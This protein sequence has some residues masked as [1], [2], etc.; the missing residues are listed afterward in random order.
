MSQA[1]SD[2]PPAG[3]SGRERLA[4]V[5]L[6]AALGV[7]ILVRGTTRRADSARTPLDLD[8]LVIHA[9]GLRAEAAT[10]TALA[11]DL[12]FDPADMLLWVNAF[13]QGTDAHRSARSLLDGDLARDLDAPAVELSLPVRLAARGWRTLLIDD[14][15]P[16]ASR[17]QSGFGVSIPIPDAESAPGALAAQW[18]Q[19]ASVAP[20]F[21]FVHLG[22]G[23]EPLHSDTTEAYVLQERY[24]LRLRRIRAVVRDVARAA[25]SGRPQLVV[26]MGA[27][28][29]AL[30]EHPQANELPHDELV[31]VPLLM[32]LRNASGLPTG[33]F[34]A[35][36][37]SADLGP[38]ILDVL[39]LRTRAERATDG[40]ARAGRSLEPHIHGWRTGPVHEELVL[41]GV[42]HV[43]VRSARWKLIA[44]I[45]PP[46][47]PR[48]AGAQ[49]YSLQEDP[50]EL[51][52][53]L[54]G[55]EPG[56]V[57]G[58]LFDV[59]TDRFGDPRASL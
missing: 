29:L 43:A 2:L 44:P 36:V 27:S 54:D 35:L 15:D 13:A 47:R 41:F 7:L 3:W 58:A 34:P 39:D 56:P 28:G 48:R 51:H 31:R 10:T 4:L 42:E 45:D 59:M 24:R 5:L 25:H 26:L 18:P 49:L 55:A 22:F 40:V 32:G 30:G 46:L 20:T 33:A 38:T 1:P 8:V 6:L 17:L 57:S 19:S 21:A 14:T 12:N 50:G 53:L 52:D 16:L 11:N 37:Q 9:A 23:E